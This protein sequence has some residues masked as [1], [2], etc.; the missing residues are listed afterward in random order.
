MPSPPAIWSAPLLPRSRSSPAAPSIVSAPPR[1]ISTS[2]RALPTS[3]SLFKEP[4]IPSMLMRVSELP[5]P[6]LP[7]T[8]A[9][10]DA[11]MPDG[12]FGY[13]AK[14]TPDPPFR[15]S[16]PAP[17]VRVSLPSPPAIWSA[18]SVPKSA[19]FPLMIATFVFLPGGPPAV[20]P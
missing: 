6:S 9:A 18:A 15:T 3:R 8:P 13:S 14:S 12:E 2:G 11:S 10:I 1:P 16:A 7:T 5:V 17:P 20:Q 19:P 4:T